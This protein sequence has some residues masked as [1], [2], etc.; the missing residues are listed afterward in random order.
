VGR[1]VVE[2]HG[3]TNLDFRKWCTEELEKL[4]PDGY[5][6]GGLS[7]GESKEEMIRIL[8]ESTHLLPEDKPRYLMGVGSAEELLNAV[9]H[10]VDIFDS[11][12]PT[13][14]AR[15]GTIFT[16]EGRYNMRG[17]KLEQDDRPLD[18][19]CDCWTCKTYSRSYIN[20]LLRVKEMLGMRLTTMHNLHYMQ[21]LVRRAREAIV[22][23]TY[24][25]FRKEV[26]AAVDF[27][28]M[29]GPA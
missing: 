11:V 12:F 18:P 13:Q 24:Q 28:K 8:H 23:G 29:K 14:C 21:N 16:R 27:D 17:A 19:S 4:S 5:G 10:G 9:E 6:I 22:A 7:I 20:H 1:A 26:R 15:H 25:A 3:G 2:Q